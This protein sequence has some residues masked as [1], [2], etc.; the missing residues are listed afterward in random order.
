MTPQEKAKRYDE[1]T[2][3]VKDF[4][5]GKQKM[6]ND[7]DKTLELLFPELKESDDERIRKAIISGMTAIKGQGKETFATIRINDCIAWLEKQGKQKSQGKTA[8]E[9]LKEEKV[10]NQNCI[11]SVD[12]TSIAVN[13]PDAY[14]IGFADGETHA[15][16]EQWKPSDE[17]IKHL[18]DVV[19]DAKHKNSISTNGYGPYIHLSTLLQQLKKLKEK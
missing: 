14:K 2:K 10:D 1:L 17:Q 9:A 12:E 6:P 5:E 11:K 19:N 8:L 7:V 4:F 3:E 13:N 16:E 18:T 15:K